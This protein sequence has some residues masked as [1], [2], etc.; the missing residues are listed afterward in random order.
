MAFPNSFN[1]GH[2]TH[3]ETLIYFNGKIK[4][5]HSCI[6]THTIKQSTTPGNCFV[7]AISTE[8]ASIHLR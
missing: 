4:Y 2:Y 8:P 3:N 5:T 7:E 6:Q 1:L